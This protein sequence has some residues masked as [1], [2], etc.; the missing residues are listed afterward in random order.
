MLTAEE[1]TLIWV[2][3]EQSL[4]IS[5]P[6][7]GGTVLDMVTVVRPVQ[8]ANACNPM[9]VILLGT[10]ML[11]RPDPANALLLISVMLLGMVML[12][13]FPQPS[14]VLCS[15]YD[16]LVGMLI[17]TRLLQLKNAPIPILDTV[18]DIDT[19]VRRVRS[20]KADSSILVTVYP[21]IVLG[22]CMLVRPYASG[23]N[24]VTV[25]FDPSASCSR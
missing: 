12:T 14:K 7:L 9:L 2:R 1:G 22:I 15:I 6:T 10:V 23:R 13:S 5:E 11:V 20:V 8:F 24:P 18:F 4:N 16:M 21:L 25:I 17:L 3:L 19:S